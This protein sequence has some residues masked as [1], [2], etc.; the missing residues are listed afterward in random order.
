MQASFFVRLNMSDEDQQLLIN[1]DEDAFDQEETIEPDNGVSQEEEKLQQSSAFVARLQK[2]P[3]IGFIL[4]LLGCFALTGAGVIV[5]V[6]Y[7]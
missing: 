4:V 1:S 2:I 3:L 6:R 7:S 5:K